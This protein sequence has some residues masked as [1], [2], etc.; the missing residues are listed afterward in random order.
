MSVER[1]PACQKLNRVPDH[2]A[3]TARCG[4]CGATLTGRPAQNTAAPSGDL[5]RLV[6]ERWDA[7]VRY[8]PPNTA[9]SRAT[10]RG[11]THDPAG[12]PVGWLSS[13]AQM[14]RDELDQLRLLRV[15]L[16]SNKTFP[17][18]ILTRALATL[19]QAHSAIQRSHL[20]PG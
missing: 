1:C 2:D 20:A 11:G 18:Q 7:L 4:S 13:A 5:S 6:I 12:D 19:D 16:A 8:V 15:H 10:G 3:G 17:P 14:P 9:L